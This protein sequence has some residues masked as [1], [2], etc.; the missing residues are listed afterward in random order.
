[1]A[2]SADIKVSYI[3]LF[4]FTCLAIGI[5]SVIRVETKNFGTVADP[6]GDDPYGDGDGDGGGTTGARVNNTSI[7]NTDDFSFEGANTDTVNMGNDVILSQ[8]AG[9]FYI[10]G[11]DGIINTFDFSNQ[12][13]NTADITVDQLLDG[14]VRMTDGLAEYRI[15]SPADIVA[16]IPDM[17]VNDCIKWSLFTGVA[18][19]S[20][21]TI[22]QTD[23]ASSFVGSNSMWGPFFGGEKNSGSGTFATCLTV[24]DPPDM[25][26]YRLA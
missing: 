14:Y 22:V 21:S 8:K 19:A 15:A 1:M 10:D 26:T 2:I 7:D 4:T 17:Q 20:P 25:V 16:A 18:A 24:L 5:Y 6:G 13:D 11:A 9:A 12:A 23:N 3:W